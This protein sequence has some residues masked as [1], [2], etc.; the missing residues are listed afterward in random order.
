MRGTRHERGAARKSGSGRWIDCE[1]L[2]G[3]L[4]L[5]API[6]NDPDRILPA[7]ILEIS[8]RMGDAPA[9]LSDQKALP[10]ARSLSAQTSVRDRRSIRDF[11]K[12]MWFAC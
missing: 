11:G 4:E 5:T 10:I 1:G 9:L 6:A 12:A 7:V 3:V 2:A 8:A